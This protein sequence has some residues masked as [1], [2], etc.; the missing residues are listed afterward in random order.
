MRRLAVW[1]LLLAATA[2]A[3]GKKPPAAPEAPAPLA[4]PTTAPEPSPPP[5][6][7]PVPVPAPTA[8]LT[9]TVVYRQ[10]IALTPEAVVQVELRDVSRA[11]A[12]APLVGKQIIE[13]PGQVPIAFAIP[14]SD[15]D[16]EPSHLYA[17]SARITD[18]GQLQFV[19]DT[20][21]AVLTN[22]APQDGV[23]IVVVPVK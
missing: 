7:S 12:E 17:V 18:R 16:V 22:G 19:T 10:R 3:G 8:T 4:A 15:A 20:R 9:G 21:I 23:E 14:Y 13:K 1:T 5:A 2:C 11:D 6:P